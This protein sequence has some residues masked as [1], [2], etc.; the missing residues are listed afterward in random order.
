MK[1]GMKYRAVVTDVADPRG[2]GRIKAR[3]VGWGDSDSDGKHNITP[4]MWPCVAFAADGSGVF[5]EP[6]V[7]AEVWAEQ[8]AEGDWLWTGGFWSDRNPAPADASPDVRVIRTPAGHQIKLD[9]AGDIE[10]THANGNLVALRQGGNIDII[11]SG[12]ANVTAT[13]KVVVDG[14]AVEL[15][16][17]VF[18]VVTTGHICAF[19]GAPHVQGSST[20][21][22][23]L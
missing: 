6:P 14:S 10:I 17:N 11:V 21:K 8:S 16:D 9:E 20:V 5:M 13:G 19:T 22:A 7:G 12:D 2:L 4:W 3:L 15:N 23:E 1:Y 18:K